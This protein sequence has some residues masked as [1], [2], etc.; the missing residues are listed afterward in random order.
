MELAVFAVEVEIQVFVVHQLVDAFADFL[1][2]GD[3]VQIVVGGFVLRVHPFIHFALLVAHGFHAGAAFVEF[4]VF[5]VGTEEVALA[6]FAGFVA[7][8][9][10]NAVDVFQ[11][12]V[13]VDVGIAVVALDAVVAFEFADVGIGGFVA[14]VGAQAGIAVFAGFEAVGFILADAGC[15]IAVF[16]GVGVGGA[17]AAFGS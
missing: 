2:I 11:P 6:V 5:P 16:C 17:L 13:F 7:V 12:A 9:G 3:F 15:G 10:F 4:G 8:F 14:A 1:D